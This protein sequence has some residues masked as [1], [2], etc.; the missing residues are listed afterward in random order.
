MTTIQ[1][2]AAWAWVLCV[3][4]PAYAG[5]SAQ[6]SGLALHIGGG[7]GLGDGPITPGIGW[8][9]GLGGWVGKYDDAFSL[10]RHIGFGVVVRQDIQ[11]HAARS[12]LRTTTLL[13]V[14]R[15]IDLLVI[16]LQLGGAAG[17]LFET[18]TGQPTQFAGVAARITGLAKYRF[19]PRWGLF[20]RFEAG[21]DVYTPTVGGDPTRVYG[22][23]GTM[24]G[25]EFA[26]PTTVRKR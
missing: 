18:P 4:S 9:A 11:L 21:A 1:N 5:L 22:A 15:G 16:G 2:A 25:I 7:L 3:S 19:K 14:H 23:A 24:L 20:L 6:Q 26:T 17:P 10:G 13:Q 8:T 12:G